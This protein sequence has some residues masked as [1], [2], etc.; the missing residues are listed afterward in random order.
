MMTGKNIRTGKP[1]KL[2]ALSNQHNKSC[3]V[4]D[5]SLSKRDHNFLQ[6]FDFGI[7]VS[8][9]ALKVIALSVPPIH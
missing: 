3:L 5:H 4:A 9:N 1:G 7:R 6:L 2:A 8:S